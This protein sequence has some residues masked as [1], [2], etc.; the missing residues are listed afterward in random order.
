MNV[1]AAIEG[2][3]QIWVSSA[4]A[5]LRH[6]HERRGQAHR[7]SARQASYLASSGASG[8]DTGFINPGV[9]APE[10]GANGWDRSESPGS[11][12]LAIFR[13]L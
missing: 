3:G 2:H 9:A 4:L 10:D 7:T 1:T 13:R 5:T 11:T 8:R 6:G 12:A